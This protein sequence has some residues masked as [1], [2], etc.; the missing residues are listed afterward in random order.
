[1]SEIKNGGLDQYGTEPFEQ[2]QSGTAGGEGVNSE[3]EYTW[4]IW[5]PSRMQPSFAASP[6]GSTCKTARSNKLLFH[7]KPSPNK[8]NS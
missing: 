2:Q 6:V 3:M 4:I 1:M 7:W 5:S 8:I